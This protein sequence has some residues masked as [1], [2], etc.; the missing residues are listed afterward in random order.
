MEKF[1]PKCGKK[2]LKGTFC[3]DCS[4]ITLEYK[5]L[6]IRLC[7]SNRYFYKGKWSKFKTLESLTKKLLKMHIPRKVELIQGLEQ[8][9]LLNKPGLKKDLP[10]FVEVEGAE[11]EVIIY[12]EVTYSPN[13][14]KSG[15]E[16]FEGILQ[17]RNTRPD[18]NKYIKNLL[19][20]EKIQ[21]NNQVHKDNSSDY[22]FVDKKKILKTAGKIQK[23]FSGSIEMNRQ[24]FSKNRQTSKDI[25]RI[26]VLITIPN[27]RVGDIV[28]LNDMPLAITGLGKE[29]TAFNLEKEKKFTFSTNQEQPVLIEKQKSQVTKTKPRL[30]IFNENYESQP[31][32]NP[33]DVKLKPGQKVTYVKHKKYYVLK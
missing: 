20:K 33:Y 27:Y 15:S 9:E 32:K 21:I 12:V 16:Y 3:K 18:V 6:K 14:A 10:V 25:Y 29:N 17:V 24:L 30:E 11:F 8:Y 22:Y 13:I 5:P 4:P 2:V 26:N 28:L 31:A 23:N 19:L 1:C 7:P